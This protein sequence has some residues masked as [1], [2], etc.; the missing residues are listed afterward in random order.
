MSLKFDIDIIDRPDQKIVSQGKSYVAL[1]DKYL[2]Y[3]MDFVMESPKDDT[4]ASL[5]SEDIVIQSDIS[6]KKDHITLVDFFL[7]SD[8]PGRF[9]FTLYLEKQIY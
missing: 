1:L 8:G 9:L 3:H 5:G 6:L 7:T 4:D 2:R